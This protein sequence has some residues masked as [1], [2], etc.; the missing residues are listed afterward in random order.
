M[1]LHRT[2]LAW[3]AVVAAGVTVAACGSSGDTTTG[4]VAPTDPVA[5]TLGG[6]LVSP[7]F[8]GA[9][10]DQPPALLA[11]NDFPSELLPPGG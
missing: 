10:P 6:D 11:A 7:G 1:A 4:P 8:S 9:V 3:M 2:L 5:A